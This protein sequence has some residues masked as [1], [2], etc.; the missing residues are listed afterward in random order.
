MYNIVLNHSIM[1]IIRQIYLL[2]FILR[3]KVMS[4]CKNYS[5]PSVFK[6]YSITKW[7]GV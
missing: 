3:K 5:V 7:I 1:I 4:N 2:K 6:Y